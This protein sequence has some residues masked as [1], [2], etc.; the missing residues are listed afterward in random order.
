MT[1]KDGEV[2]T[3]ETILLIPAG[4]VAFF[5]FLFGLVVSVDIHATPLSLSC[6]IGGVIEFSIVLRRLYVKRCL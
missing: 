6:L 3:V 1:N 5:A 2:V 4:I